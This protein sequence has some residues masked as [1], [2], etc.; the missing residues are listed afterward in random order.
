MFVK[1]CVIRQN[2]ILNVQSGNIFRFICHAT[3]KYIE[4]SGFKT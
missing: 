4:N 3:T 1:M 2:E